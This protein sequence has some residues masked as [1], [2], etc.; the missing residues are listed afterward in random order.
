M[1]ADVA[2]V[3]GNYQGEHVLPDCLESLAAQTRPPREVIVVDG[4]LD[5]PQRRSSPSSSA[6][7][8][9][10]APNRGLGFLYNLG[11]RGGRRRVR[12]ALEQRRRAR[13]GLPRAT[14]PPRSTRTQRASPPTRR[15]ST[16]SGE[17]VDPRAHD[18][19]AAAGCW[20]EFLPGLHL[21]DDRARR[22]RRADGVRERRRD[23]R[24]TRDCC[25]SSAASTRRSSWSGRTSTSAG[26][27]GCAAGRASTSRTRGSATASAP[28]DDGDVR[29]TAERVVAP[30][31]GPLRAQVPAGV[32]RRARRRRRAAPPA[33]ASARDRAGARRRSR[34][35][36]PRSRASAASSRPRARAARLDARRAAGMSRAAASS[37][38]RTTTSAR[39][40]PGPASAT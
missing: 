30:Q 8:C 9:L 7:A 19:R 10:H 37:S 25:S 29:A 38:S 40:W 33:D 35:S 2:V 3:V 34:A 11:A 18:A 39:A 16:G 32:G 12:A 22:R 1:T 6:R 26:A 28:Y 24:P 36:C 5:R 15:S 23:A 14:S 21:D 13:A 31:P 20:R 4:A 27:P 17:R